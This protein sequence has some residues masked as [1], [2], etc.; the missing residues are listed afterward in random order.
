MGKE[1]ELID[2]LRRHGLKIAAAESLT[3]GMVSAALV[4]VP[5]ASNAFME[6]F[7]TYDIGAK[8]RTLG[9][10]RKV[11]DKEGAIS[12]VTASLMAFGASQKAGV[13]IAIATTGNAG[14]DPSENKPVGLVYTAV[15]YNKCKNV[16]E[17]NF[18]GTRA[19]IRQQ[20]VD[21]VIGEALDILKKSF[22]EEAV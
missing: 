4:S 13:D 19:E 2:I 7:I 22:G 16:F 10:D 6:G 11:L 9:I 12:P 21:A 18:K 1:A 3:G 20:T 14:P 17:H 15:C 5:G 8:E